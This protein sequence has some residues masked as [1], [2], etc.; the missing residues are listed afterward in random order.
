MRQCQM[1]FA[2]YTWR[3]NPYKLSFHSEKN[4][5]ELLPP[6]SS[7]DIRTF[8]QK[9]CVIKG[10]GELFGEDC[11]EQ[12]IRL[13]TLFS[14]Q[15]EGVLSIEGAGSFYVAFV[16]L[17]ML[18]EPKDNLLSYSFAFRQ[19]RF[20]KTEITE[21]EYVTANADETLWDIAFHRNMTVEELIGLNPQIRFFD[22][23]REGERVRVC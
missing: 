6:F 11:I 13:K 17:S 14:Q 8:S 22:E 7:S 3:H 10:E 1:R 15:E 4:I 19:K 23:L 12:Y 21:E 16:S 2:G 20:E 5:I 18:S 9:P